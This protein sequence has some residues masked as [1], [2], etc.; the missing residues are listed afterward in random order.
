MLDVLTAWHVHEMSWPN[1]RYAIIYYNT[2]C[3]S[4]TDS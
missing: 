2:Q 1:V 3:S 4:C